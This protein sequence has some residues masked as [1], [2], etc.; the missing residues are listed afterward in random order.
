[1]IINKEILIEAI[2]EKL[3]DDACYDGEKPYRFK[4]VDDVHDTALFTKLDIENYDIMY[5]E[6]LALL[7]T[8]GEE[9]IEEIN[10]YIDEEFQTYYGDPAF[11][12]A[13]DYWGYILG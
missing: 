3:Y 9:I 13:Q 6:M 11:S 4:D 1:M 10:D 12:S 5:Y 2:K 8:D 7:N